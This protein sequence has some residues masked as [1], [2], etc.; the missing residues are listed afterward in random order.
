ML[1]DASSIQGYAVQGS[2]GPLGLIS[3]M[4]FSDTDWIVRWTVVDTG[5]MLPDRKVLLPM[6]SLGIPNVSHRTMPVKLTVKQ[7]T[8]SPGS[9][10]DEPVSRKMEKLLYDHYS[11]DPYWIE[12][13]YLTPRRPDGDTHLRSIAEI[14]GYRIE[15]TDGEIG[16]IED[17]LL[18]GRNWSIRYLLVDT[19]N[20]WPGRKVLISPHSVKVISW[21]G[22]QI[23]LAVNR[24]KVETSPPYTDTSTVDGAYDAS[25]LT[26]YSI[27]RLNT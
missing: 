23:A 11:H 22:R 10:T 3:D 26:H 4:L 19:G 5:Q 15:A 21:P 14:T 6:A 24:H 25:F 1:W 16:H 20:L 18:D 27:K 9:E 13:L 17:L 7:I 12:S 2:D 8:D